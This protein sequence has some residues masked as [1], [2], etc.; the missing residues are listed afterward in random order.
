VW[1]DVRAMLPGDDERVAERLDAL[2]GGGP[3]A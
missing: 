3:G 1:I 2:L